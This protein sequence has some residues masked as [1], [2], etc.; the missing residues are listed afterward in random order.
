MKVKGFEGEG[1]Q[2]GGRWEG[3]GMRFKKRGGFFRRRG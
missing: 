2:R 3:F 1:Y